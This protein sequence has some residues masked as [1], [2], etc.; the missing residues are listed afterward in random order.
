MQQV[1]QESLNII[2]PMVSKGDDFESDFFGGI[3]DEF[4]SLARAAIAF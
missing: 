2:I 1:H 4:S 3:E